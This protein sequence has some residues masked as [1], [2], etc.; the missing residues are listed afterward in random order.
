MVTFHFSQGTSE[1]NRTNT[2]FYFPIRAGNRVLRQVV[3]AAHHGHKKGEGVGIATT[4]FLDALL[5]TSVCRRQHGLL[6]LVI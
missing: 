5:H 1:K 3:N 4:L 2:S 6:V